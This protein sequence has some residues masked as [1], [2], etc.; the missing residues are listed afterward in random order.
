MNDQEK[1]EAMIQAVKD[2]LMVE[3]KG[4]Q[5]YSHAAETA[6][7][8]EVKEMFQM[9][10]ND[11]ENHVKM[12]QAQFKP[13]MEEGRIVLEGF[14]PAELDHGSQSIIP[15]S[16]KKK[17]KG[18]E[19]EMAVI[20]IGCQLEVQAIAHYK[21]KAKNIEDPDLKQLFSWLSD[22][23]EDHLNQLRELETMYQD[24]YWAEQGFSPM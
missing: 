2:A 16:F 9:L 11:E 24:A 17:I 18:G 15:D 5:L 8:P 19:F 4:Q 1:R 3:I 10:A 21:S 22:W 12:L 13:I 6:K 20:G 7:D 23:E 14:H